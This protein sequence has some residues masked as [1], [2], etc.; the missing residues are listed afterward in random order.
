MAIC[1]LKGL[2]PATHRPLRADNATIKFAARGPYPGSRPLNLDR[3]LVFLLYQKG[4]DF[5][6]F[7]APATAD[8]LRHR[9]R[10]S[11]RA[12]I[13]YGIATGY[14]RGRTVQRTSRHV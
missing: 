6:I 10:L 11:A 8:R 14:L 4:R 12:L 13:D 9:H 1:F 2:L 7:Q 3:L 5:R